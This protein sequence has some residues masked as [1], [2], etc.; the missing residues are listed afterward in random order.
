MARQQNP[1]GKVQRSE[2]DAADTEC[3]GS[4]V[5]GAVAP[6]K[7]LPPCEVCEAPGTGFHYGVTTC[8]PCK[9]SNIIQI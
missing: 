3:E 4:P 5:S 1:S 9:V 8:E 2:K 7:L 6:V